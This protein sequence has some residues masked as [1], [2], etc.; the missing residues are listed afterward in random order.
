LSDRYASGLKA[1]GVRRGDRTLLLVKPS[2]DFYGLL[3]G[4]IKLGA[5][6][7]LLDPGMGLKNV[8]K[9]IAQIRPRVVIALPA[10]HVIRLLVR[11]PFA[12]A[13][14]LVTA[15]RRLFWGGVSLDACLGPDAPFEL[16]AFAPS[17]EVGIVFTS[18]STGLPKGVTY[19]HAVFD[20]VAE[21]ADA[22]LGRVPGR[23]YLET[24]A[25]YVLFDVAQGMTSVVPAMD[26]SKPAKVDPAKLV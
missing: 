1:Q 6:P 22:R 15:G 13:E 2:P 10:V 16:E 8:L 7:V 21:V 26:L 5:V 20:A 3:F 12:S 24:F 11:R 17:D 18:G 23:V 19:T 25:A 14:I 4:L 9:C